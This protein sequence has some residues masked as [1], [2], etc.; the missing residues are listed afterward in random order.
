MV[1][2]AGAARTLA[3]LLLLVGA[4]GAAVNG[5]TSRFDVVVY[6]ASSGG[7]MAAVAAGRHGSKT[8]LLCASWPACFHE[9]GRIIGGMSGGGL[10]QTDIGGHTEIIGGLAR[11]FYERN[12]QHYESA[13]QP[14]VAAVSGASSCRLP[15]Q[16]CNATYNLEPHVAQSIFT[17]MLN[18]AGVKV[19]FAAQVEKVTKQ[20]SAVTTI[21]LTDGNV[22]QAKVFI[23]AS[24]V[25]SCLSLSRCPRIR[26]EI[27]RLGIAVDEVFAAVH[28]RL[29]L[30][31]NA[32][33]RKVTCS[34]V[35]RLPT[36]SGVNPTPRSK[37][38]WL[39]VRS[40]LTRI[41]STLRWILSTPPGKC[42]RC[43]R[44]LIAL[45]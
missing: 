3:P 13:Q 9:G 2:L 39:V 38:V 16:G 30:L 24:Y 29:N 42:C 34:R 36:S 15:A 37:R 5:N 26:A 40:A 44:R 1:P 12:R 28:W 21:A 27:L 14:I 19:F 23:D 31:P 18:D 10:G 33:R 35:Q 8:A 32:P 7:V 22:Y 4:V 43:S 20:G 17:T 11:E 25:S 41:S 45:L 6:D